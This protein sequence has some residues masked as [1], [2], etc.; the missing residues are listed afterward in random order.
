VFELVA[1]LRALHGH[2]GVLA[3]AALL[4]PVFTLRT[5]PLRRGTRYGVV[6][7]SL[8]AVATFSAGWALYPGYR[9][10]T[11]RELLAH[12]SGLARAFETKEH[13]AFYVV[14]L[15]LAGL[16]L[17]LWAPDGPGLRAAR[18]CYGLASALAFVVAALGSTVGAWH[19]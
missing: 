4:H 3:A 5:G 12:A 14:V 7:A 13:L 16:G 15:A 19:G 9:E 10:G 8:L 2:V 11:R 6:A 1:L 17:A 18:W